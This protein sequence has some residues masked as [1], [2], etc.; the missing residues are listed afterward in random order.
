MD[1]KVEDVI[2]G[3]NMS[4]TDREMKSDESS[5]TS[6][7]QIRDDDDAHCPQCLIVF[8]SVKARKN[9]LRRTHPDQYN[10]QLMQNNTL[11][12]CYKCDRL[13]ATPEELKV[14]N[15]LHHPVDEIP[16]CSFCSEVFINF[17]ALYK[18]KR[19]P[20]V[21]GV[22]RC[23]ECKVGCRSLLDFHL[24]C[25]EEHDRDVVAASQSDGRM[26]SICWRHF[27]TNEALQSHQDRANNA[28]MKPTVKCNMP[29]KTKKARGKKRKRRIEEEDDDDNEDEDEKEEE[30][31]KIPC[32][33]EDCDLLFP[34]IDALRAH[35][36]SQHS[37]LP[38]SSLNCKKR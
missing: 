26:C 11:F 37:A 29:A 25:I 1:K 33:E 4:T 32:P 18:H 15:E 16:V 12:S 7:L 30:E 31:L 6:L 17:S 28:E 19:M 2:V 20:C 21:E 14:H 22:W 8:D 10:I 13:F 36:R 38:P 35:K 5:A 24:H 23:R 27:L 3:T 9:H 34:S